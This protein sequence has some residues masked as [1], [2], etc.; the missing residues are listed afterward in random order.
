VLG[1]GHV[2][3]QNRFLEEINLRS[4]L[5]HYSGVIMGISAGSMNCADIVY[6]Q[7]EESGESIDPN[8]KRFIKGLGLTQTQILPHYQKVCHNILDG[9]RLYEDIT[10]SDSLGHTFY[11][12]V[13]GSYLIRENGTEIIRG[14]SYKISNGTIKKICNLEEEFI[15][16]D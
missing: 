13:D 16:Q 8:Y 15:L 11:V 4:I 7:P 14:E 9:K 3:T 5:A 12:L 1:G 6:A 2:P 10:L